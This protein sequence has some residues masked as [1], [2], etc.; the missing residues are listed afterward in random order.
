[1][2]EL[3]ERPLWR[4]F[5]PTRLSA[6]ARHARAG[7]LSVVR[8]R[9]WFLLGD[10]GDPDD[11]EPPLF[12]DWAIRAVEAPTWRELTEGP[13][14]GLIQARVSVDWRARVEEWMARDRRFPGGTARTAFDC[15]KCG[16][17]CKAN[18]VV[19]DEADVA[20]LQRGGRE[21]SRHIV[22]KNG[23][24]LLPLVG[25]DERCVHLADACTIYEHR[26]WMCR[27]FQVGS[28]QCMTSREEAYGGPFAEGP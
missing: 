9:S 20:R 27:D 11:P 25:D 7:G 16:A 2:R 10:A 4:G 24:R 14:A 13:A 8:A 18:A 22:R 28:E 3:V 12:V 21:V 17:C 1:M 19:L 5:A 15:M 23:R 26:P 6:A